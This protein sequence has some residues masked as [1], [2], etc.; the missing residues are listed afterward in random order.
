MNSTQAIR[1]RLLEAGVSFAPNANI[2][3]H[4]RPGDIEVIQA[5]FERHMQDVLDAL[6]ID[7]N[8]DHNTQGTAKRIAKMYVREVFAGRFEAA[9]EVTD[10]QNDS[11]PD[12][13]YSLGPIAVRSACAHHL[14]PVTGRMWVGVLP[15]DKL[16]GISKFV[17]LANWIL[18]RPHLQEEATVMLADELE[19]RLK[20]KELAVVLKAQHQCM[21]W[22][23]VREAGTIMTTS[24]MRGAFP[25]LNG[26]AKPHGAAWRTSLSYRQLA[27]KNLPNTSTASAATGCWSKDLLRVAGWCQ[28]R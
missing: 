7:T 27:A 14:V 3:E 2:A 6:V 24:I 13:V 25:S 17:R 5:E 15:G 9:P 11:G 21:A 1:K 16:I 22:R 8:R 20:P 4:L 10:F 18:S 28:S 12:E 26:S 19:G 23:G